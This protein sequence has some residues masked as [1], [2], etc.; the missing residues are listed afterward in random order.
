MLRNSLLAQNSRCWMVLVRSFESQ[1]VTR[2]VII[3]IENTFVERRAMAH[4]E[5]AS[6]SGLK[7]K[8]IAHLCPLAILNQSDLEKLA[9]VMRLIFLKRWK[10]IGLT[11]NRSIGISKSLVPL[12][13]GRK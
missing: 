2:L 3:S 5:V 9:N 6:S 8:S 13:T 10:I 12:M 1:R 11:L 7:P 4:S